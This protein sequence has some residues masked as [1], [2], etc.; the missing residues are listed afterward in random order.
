M[1]ILIVAAYLAYL[2]FVSLIFVVIYGKFGDFRRA[3]T[4]AL[5]IA[6]MWLAVYSLIKIDV[7]LWVLYSKKT[8]AVLAEVTFNEVQFAAL[9]L[10]N[11]WLNRDTII[12]I[13]SG[14]GP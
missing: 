14:R 4:V 2:V 11:L 9:L 6:K 13:M 7:P 5:I 12:R 1:N 8:G 3:T 10:T